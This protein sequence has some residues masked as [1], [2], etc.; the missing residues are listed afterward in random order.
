MLHICDI[1]YIYVIYARQLIKRDRHAAHIFF[2]LLEPL[3]Q[4]QL[5]LHYIT[6]YV[7][8]YSLQSTHYIQPT[9]SMLLTDKRTLTNS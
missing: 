4:L 9:Y 6:E 7:S 3:Q 5:N 8:Q 2:Y 1:C